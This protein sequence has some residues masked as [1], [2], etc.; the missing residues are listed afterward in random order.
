[1]ADPRMM[2]LNL[3]VSDLDASKA[4]F[5]KLGFSFDPKFTDENAACMIFADQHAYAML[6]KE[7]FFDT[8]HTRERCDTKKHIEGLFAFSCGSRAEVDLIASAAVDAGGSLAGD[9]LDY[10]FMYGQRFLDLDGHQ[11]EVLWMDTQGGREGARVMQSALA[12][13][14]IETHRVALTGHCYRML[15]SLSDA[16]DAVQE[17]M[18]RAWRGLERFDGRAALTTWLHRIATNVCLDALKRRKRRERPISDGPIGTVDDELLERPREHWLEPM[19]DRAV[20]PADVSPERKVELQQSIRLAFVAALQ[21]LPPRQRAVL[22]LREVVGWSAQEVAEALDTSV[23]AANSAL[24]RA[25]RDAVGERASTPRRRTHWTRRS[26]R[27]SIAT[28]PRSTTT[29]SGRSPT[30]CGRTRSCRCR[31]SRSG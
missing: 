5:A 18:V 30:C 19:P 13:E 27:C 31:R 20:I 6:L 23:A 1:M 26:A 16:D 12:V 25:P 21:H 15:G 8:F 3:P 17:T 11:W 4:F 28:S 29:T 9:A 7:P 2:F 10:G 24:Q 14:Q 22:I